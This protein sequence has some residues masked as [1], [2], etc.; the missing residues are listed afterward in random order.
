MT[1]GQCS[2]CA[3]WWERE[4]FAACCRPRA[5]SSALVNQVAPPGAH[6]PGSHPGR[7]LGLRPCDWCQ[8]SP[9]PQSNTQAPSTL[10]AARPMGSC[11]VAAHGGRALPCPCPAGAHC[12][13]VPCQL[14]AS[15]C[16]PR[17]PA[18][19]GPAITAHELDSGVLASPWQ[20]EVA[21]DAHTMSGRAG[22]HRASHSQELLRDSGLCKVLPDATGSRA[23]DA[24]TG[25][26]CHDLL[27]SARARLQ[28]GGR[29]QLASPLGGCFQP[30]P[31]GQ[32]P[33]VPPGSGG[34]DSPL[35]QAWAPVPGLPASQEELE[36]GGGQ[37][38]S[39]LNPATGRCWVLLGNPGTG[40]STGPLAAPSLPPRR[41]L[42]QWLAV[43]V[44]ESEQEVWEALGTSCHWTP[45]MAMPTGSPAQ[46]R[47]VGALQPQRGEVAVL[48]GAVGRSSGEE[49]RSGWEAGGGPAQCLG[50]LLRPSLPRLS[51]GASVASRVMRCILGPFS[52]LATEGPLGAVSVRSVE[53]GQDAP[54]CGGNWP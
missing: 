8:G 25:E 44:L 35:S 7:A 34:G 3:C 24:G 48:A 5:A 27:P 30:S 20:W 33:V 13:L 14:G 37:P 18:A 9:G 23:R 49:P 19:D 36:P 2:R 17:S 38:F 39:G 45:G 46:D 40:G 43:P 10:L 1:W 6:G 50:G 47:P 53:G 52:P 29:R 28:V 54:L 21:W 26:G 15:C 31:Y 32:T 41:G 42:Y 16:P 22:R 11:A 4:P 12:S 51:P